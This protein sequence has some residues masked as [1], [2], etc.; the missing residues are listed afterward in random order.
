MN[1]QKTDYTDYTIED[2]GHD[3]ANLEEM[4]SKSEVAQPSLKS[5]ENDDMIL[6]YTNHEE[7][8]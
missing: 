1:N 6:M 4:L 3:M 8:C 5:N 2:F 7:G